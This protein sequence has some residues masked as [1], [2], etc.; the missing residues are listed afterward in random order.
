[1]RW[2]QGRQSTNVRDVRGSRRI[3]GG[4][5]GL[6]GGALVIMLIVWLLGGNPLQVLQMI[7]GEDSH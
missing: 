4:G 2:R 3:A 5:A 1:M 6:G 7:G